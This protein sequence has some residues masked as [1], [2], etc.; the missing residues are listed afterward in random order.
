VIVISH[1][2]P[3]AVDGPG[4]RKNNFR[5][6]DMRRII[7]T[8]IIVFIFVSVWVSVMPGYGE[9]KA[10]KEA[11]MVSDGNTVKVHYTLTVEGEVVDSS[12][13]KDPLEF[14]VGSS[15]VIP[16]FEKS[17]VGMKKGDQKSF[18]ISPE[19][20]YG[21]VDPNGVKEIPRDNL[22]PDVKPEVGMTLYATSPDGQAIPLKIAEVK[23]NAIVIDMNHPL[24]GKTLNFEVEVVEIK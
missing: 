12:D 17:V 10:E 6:A 15:Q 20:G 16:G 4:P 24:A 21:K 2:P 22:P 14:E 23:E 5:E 11:I 13:G 19:D 8:G 7:C 1:V 3:G 9:N 18:E